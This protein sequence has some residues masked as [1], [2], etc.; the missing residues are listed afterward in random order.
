MLEIMFARDVAATT[1][2]VR[3]PVT[4]NMLLGGDSSH[5]GFGVTTKKI[6]HNLKISND[7]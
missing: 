6:K 5:T 2:N 3:N 7:F 4:E 1:E